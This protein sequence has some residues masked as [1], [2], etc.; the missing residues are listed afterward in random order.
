MSG[1][2][3][4]TRQGPSETFYQAPRGDAFSSDLASR[5]DVL[6]VSGSV[7]LVDSQGSL[8]ILPSNAH[9]RQLA[10][11][12]IFTLCFDV[13]FGSGRATLDEHYDFGSLSVGAHD[14]GL[15]IKPAFFL[16]ARSLLADSDFGSSSSRCK[17]LVD[18]PHST[19]GFE[20][21]SFSVQFSMHQPHAISRAGVGGEILGCSG[22]CCALAVLSC[23]LSSL[24][25]GL[26]NPVLP[27]GPKRPVRLANPGG[28]PHTVT[29]PCP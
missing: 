28:C 20:H 19:W 22:G 1:V 29:P 8:T 10:G 6:R 23:V 27:L 24:Q 12:C 13:S 4:G 2:P 16:R 18:C 5:D 25:M 3:L 21:T 11:Q 26:A 17:G 14:C 9:D 15:Q 7:L